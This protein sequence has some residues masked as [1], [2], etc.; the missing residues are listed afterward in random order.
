[1]YFKKK[2]FF[3]LNIF[4]PSWIAIGLWKFLGFTHPYACMYI[5]VSLL[6]FVSYAWLNISFP[7]S[8]FILYFELNVH[9]LIAHFHPHRSSIII[10]I[11]SSLIIIGF[12]LWVDWLSVYGASFGSSPC[13]CSLHSIM[14]LNCVVIH[15]I[16]PNMRCAHLF[17]FIFWFHLMCGISHHTLSFFTIQ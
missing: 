17:H 7:Y 2:F 13:W 3:F 11:S 4:Q 5:D 15:Q 14:V 8:K 12:C 6:V 9:W 10:I 16:Q 1:M